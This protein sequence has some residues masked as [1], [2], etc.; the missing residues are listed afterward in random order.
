MTGSL[1]VRMS[2]RSMATTIGFGLLF[3]TG[4]IRGNASVITSSVVVDLGQTTITN[5]GFGGQEILGVGSTLVPVASFVPHVGDI[6]Q[7][8]ISFANND[9]LKIINGPNIVSHILGESGPDYFESLTF[10]FAGSGSHLT[11]T[12]DV[13]F[14]GLEG[15]LSDPTPGGSS[16]GGLN[17]SLYP[18]FTDSWISFTGL[19]MTTTILQLPSGAPTYDQFGLFGGRA[20]GFEVLPGPASAAP[21]PASLALFGLG[22]V[23][24]LAARRRRKLIRS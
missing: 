13:A 7:T 23:G 9:R 18:N 10:Y 1:G 8:T 11:S 20:G 5:D 19:T 15:S 16:Q 21:E 12:T 14:F 24:L 22:G 2:V 6:L 3:F 4:S 17:Q